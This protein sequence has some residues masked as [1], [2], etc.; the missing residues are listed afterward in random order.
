MAPLSAAPAFHLMQT[1]H[2]TPSDFLRRST[3]CVR[4][5][6]EPGKHVPAS[7]LRERA[8]RLWAAGRTAEAVQLE[9]LCGEL[10]QDVDILCAYPVPHERR[11]GAHAHL[12]GAHR[13]FC[14]LA[15]GTARMCTFAFG[16]SLTVTCRRSRRPFSAIDPRS[17]SR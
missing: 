12:R 4:P 14:Q 8:G 5:L 9:Q 3:V 15:A 7:L 17:S 16:L 10:A 1:S 11:S 6:P 13:C 2:L